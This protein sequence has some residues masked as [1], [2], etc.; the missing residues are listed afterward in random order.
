MATD[1]QILQ[2]IQGLLQQILPGHALRVTVD[3]NL[4]NDL[5]L[6]SLK[7]L[8]LLEKLEDAYDISIPINILAGIR[9]VGDLV[10]EIEKLT[11]S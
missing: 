10:E 7:V 6:D 1:E 2:Q 3:L 5:D 8:E 4:T 9:T 11:D